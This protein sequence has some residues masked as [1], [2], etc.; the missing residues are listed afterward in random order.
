MQFMNTG[1]VLR[2]LKPAWL[3]PVVLGLVAALQHTALA[4]EAAH[5]ICVAAA[6]ADTGYVHAIGAVPGGAL[7]GAR[8]GLFLARETA[9]KIGVGKVG[10]GPA[11]DA[12]TGRVLADSK[13][14]HA[15]RK[16][17]TAEGRLYAEADGKLFAH[18]TTSC[19]I[20]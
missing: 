12:D 4:Q 20:L 3:C 17:A 10:A 13:V 15:G 9:G 18:A 8:E 14:V 5:F 2:S 7:I 16:L 11:G 6:G 1:A 19:L